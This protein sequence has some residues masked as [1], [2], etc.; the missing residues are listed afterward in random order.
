MATINY[1]IQTIA[2]TTGLPSK[3]YRNASI[4]EDLAGLAPVLVNHI[5]LQDNAPSTST[6]AHALF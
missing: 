2:T 4:E 6:H 5:Q 1:A 3:P